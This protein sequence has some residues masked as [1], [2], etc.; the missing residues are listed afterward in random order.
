M[1]V[2]LMLSSEELAVLQPYNGKM[3][4]WVKQ[5]GIISTCDYVKPMLTE[6]MDEIDS[7]TGI[8]KD[9]NTS[10]SAIDRPFIKQAR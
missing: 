10:F 6:L 4:N 5:C 8:V 2:M 7:N 3:V 9:F 1:L